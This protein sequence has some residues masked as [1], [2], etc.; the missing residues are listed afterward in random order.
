MTGGECVVARW[1][2]VDCGYSHMGVA[3]IDEDGQ[4]LAI[5]R[6]HL[7]RGDGHSRAVALARLNVLLERLNSFADIPVW[8]AGYCYEHSGVLEAFEDTGWTVVGSKALNDVVGIYGLTDMR[9]NVI[10]GGCGSWPQMV[11]IDKANTVCWPGEDVLADMPAWPLSGRSYAEMLIRLSKR[12]DLGDQGS[13][14]QAVYE[15]LGADSIEQSGDRWG[16]LGPLMAQVLEYPEVRGFLSAAVDSIAKIRDVVWRY[17]AID[18]TPGIVVGGG[19]VS[20]EQLWAVLQSEFMS[21]S[22]AVE[23]VEGDPAVGLARFA[24]HNP[25]ADAWAVIGQVRP[26]WLS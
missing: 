15:R 26:S 23:R 25:D 13:L 22:V 2:G 10:V 19:A 16:T 12:D 1:V 14:R 18:E 8:L 11:Y 5:V 20:D 24:R 6:T 21:R 3:V 17:A 9:G 7:P 4:V